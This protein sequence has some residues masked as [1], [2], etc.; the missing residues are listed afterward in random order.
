MEEATDSHWYPPKPT[1]SGGTPRSRRMQ[2]LI[3]LFLFAV[4]FLL[5]VDGD[6]EYLIVLIGVLLI[7]EAGHALAMRAFGYQEVGILF[8]PLMGAAATGV[9]NQL[10][11]SWRSVILLAGPL[12]GILI[13][14]VLFWVGQSS[15][16]DLFIRLAWVFL[17]L[18]A[19]N[20]LPVEPLDGGKLI[21][22]LFFGNKDVL[23]AVF[24]GIS[25]GVLV[26]LALVLQS[27]L[28]GVFGILMVNRIRHIL[29][30]KDVRDNLRLQ[31]VDYQKNYEDLT[32]EEYWLIRREVLTHMPKG[33]TVKP[34]DFRPAK[35]EAVILRRVRNV[36]H[37]PLQQ[38]LNAGGKIASILLWALGLIGP[39]AMAVHYLWSDLPEL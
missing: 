30:I 35:E 26:V 17:A 28:L 11:Q 4:F 39:I 13:G 24:L 37:L 10:K 38:D 25:C 19:F 3:S 22:T 2:G 29:K 15:G 5:F 21:T 18:N 9:T 6:F 16:N 7:H 33:T 23:K 8:I 20:L 34:D 36:L 27:F 14:G 31:Q 32:D 1:V 12:P